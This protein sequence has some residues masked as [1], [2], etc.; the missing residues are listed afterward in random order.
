MN[1]SPFRVDARWIAAFT[2]LAA[3]TAGMVWGTHVA[4]G[5]D[6]YCYLSQA[7]L[8]ASG[9]IAHT[10]PLA[11][12]APWEHGRDAF[13]PV[14]YVPAFSRP[15]TSVPMCPPGY[16]MVMA[17]AHV[18]AG[19][20]AMFAVVPL[21]GGLAVWLTFVLGRRIA[22]P[23]GGAL[24]A[25]LLAA[26]PPFL[27]QIV[28]PMSDVPATAMWALALV[29]IT[30]HRFT[31]SLNRRGPL[32]GRRSLGEGGHP[33]WLTALRSLFAARSAPFAVLGGIATGAALLMR[34]NLV[35]VAGVVA[36]AVFVER[37]LRWRDVLRT[38][39]LFGAGILPFAVVVAA[40]QNAMYGGPL[41]A[42]Y[43]DLDFLFRIDHVWPNFQRYPVWLLQTETPIVLC[44]LASPWLVHSP[45][46]RRRCFWLLGFAAAVLVCYIPYEVFDAWWY[47][48]FLLPAY[49][50]LLVLTAA[51]ILG[52]LSRVPARWRALGLIAV[53]TLSIFLVRE[54]VERQAF[55]L[56]N[57]EHRFR[58]AGDYVGAELPGNAAIV[59]AHESG[60]IRFYSGRVTMTWRALPPDGLT[61]ALDFL[62]AQ[63]YRPY[64]LLEVW[65]Q[66]E[67]IA[68]FQTTSPL[69][70]LGWPPV[71][72][73]NH[74]VRIYDPDD[75]ARY[76]GGIP[77]RTDRIWK[78]RDRRHQT[79]ILYQK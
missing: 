68:R 14:G 75:Y 44:A 71:A 40:L 67:F 4:G 9:R 73:I 58:V 37:P 63:G 45:E 15:G 38:W 43:G 60:S 79:S 50:A 24:A 61:R 30:G 41:K 2:A 55:E 21:L 3:A 72:D 70:G 28:Q 23:A 20:T 27:Y 13:I 31:S 5:S 78:L 29:A 42:G 69:G 65:E 33:A 17:L 1:R 76:R 52:L 19:R 26:S 39:T 35:P 54:A 77:V 32:P 53:A 51:A 10:E 57:F 11:S 59:T 62:R 47:L 16:P 22:G 74:E 48:R 36:L 46:L 49:P 18:V 34:P 56:R 8:F 64:L 25:V 66:P 6:S 12:I 7:E